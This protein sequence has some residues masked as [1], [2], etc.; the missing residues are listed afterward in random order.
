MLSP[1]YCSMD[2]E[3]FK[4]LPNSTNAVESYNRFGRAAHR[5]PLK[6]AM[7]ATYREDMAKSLEVMACRK[8]LTTTYH[9]HSESARSKRSAQQ[10]L[11]RRKRFRDENDDPEGPPTT[12]KPSILTRAHQPDRRRKNA[13]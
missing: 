2:P 6:V 13:D 12:R 3:Q 9:S 10:G 11:A 1:V 8:G 7:M 4:G 5:Q